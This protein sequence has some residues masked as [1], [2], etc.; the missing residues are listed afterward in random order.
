MLRTASSLPPT[1]LSTLG[2]DPPG[3][4]TEPPACDRASWQL[5]GPDSH[6]QAT[7]SLRTRRST[8]QHTASPPALLGARS[9]NVIQ[10]PPRSRWPGPPAPAQPSRIQAP[11]VHPRAAAIRPAGHDDEPQG[12][13]VGAAIGCR[14]LQAAPGGLG[15]DAPV[16]LAMPVSRWPCQRL[17]CRDLPPEVGVA[18]VTFVARSTTPAA[19][20]SQEP[21]HAGRCRLRLR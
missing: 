6:R 11:V 2:F 10:H 20:A 18:A 15:V 7:P 4:P 3:F 12:G 13:Y 9:S 21:R 16:S 17:A 8:A 19:P 5:P 1:G 14:Q